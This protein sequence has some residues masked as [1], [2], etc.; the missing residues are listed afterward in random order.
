VAIAAATT[1]YPVF[2]FV[3]A[4]LASTRETCVCIGEE[5]GAQR[6]DRRRCQ[7]NSGVIRCRSDKTQVCQQR[8][9]GASDW[10]CR[11]QKLIDACTLSAGAVSFARG[12]NDTPKIVAL[13]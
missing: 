5:W 7:H 2:S 1:L 8:Y 6:H 13:T 10:W 12:M 9:T 4:R 3:R 11:A